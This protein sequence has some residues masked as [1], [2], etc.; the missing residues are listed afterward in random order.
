MTLHA[1]GLTDVGRKRKHNEDAYLV[2]AE[3]GLF[4]VADGM[5]G[6]AAGEVA[7][8]ITVESM[9]EFIAS[10]D[11]ATDSSWPFGQGNRAAS[12]GN[13]LT[14]AVEKAN[15][16]V[17]RAVAS[18]PELKGMGT[19]VVAALV[20]AQR[21]TLVHVGDSRAYLFRDGEL[22]RLTDDHSWVQEQ[23]NAGILS[24]DEAKSHPLKNVVT[25][26]LGGS[27]HVSVDLIEVPLRPGDR[28]LLCSDGLTG[29]VGDEEIHAFFEAEPSPEGAVRKLVELANERGGVDNV[30][31]I[32]VDVLM[33]AEPD[34][35]EKTH[36]VRRSEDEKTTVALPKDGKPKNEFDD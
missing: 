34:E 19:T 17:M 33:D 7:S 25:R 27:P 14:A 26:A 8:R 12:G 9:Q 3:R 24:E 28:F 30:T 22:R 15:E 1:F 21:A 6:H 29:M 20:E 36:T 13:R 31:A 5:G 18:R 10:S 2:D 4:V 23:V 35:G 16:K 11:D 32:V